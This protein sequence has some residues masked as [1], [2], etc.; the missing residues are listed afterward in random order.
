MILY[1]LLAFLIV[2]AFALVGP[3]AGAFALALFFCAYGAGA[4]AAER[5]LIH[6][7]EEADDAS[8]E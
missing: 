5:R 6:L 3:A 4:A 1:L 7:W 2:T 8:Q